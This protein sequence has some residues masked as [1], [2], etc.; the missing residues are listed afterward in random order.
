MCD[1]LTKTEELL[2]PKNTR[3]GVAFIVTNENEM[4]VRP[5]ILT[6]QIEKGRGKGKAV[7]MLPSFCPFCGTK[8]NITREET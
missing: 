4:V 3:L 2:K 5:L 6:E 8:Y 1:C 7:N